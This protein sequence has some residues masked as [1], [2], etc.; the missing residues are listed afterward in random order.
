[1]AKR[2]ERTHLGQKAAR[3][4]DLTVRS[5]DRQTQLMFGKWVMRFLEKIGTG[6]QAAA[7]DTLE[8]AGCLFED[9]EWALYWA[10]SAID[11][12][13]CL[14]SRSRAFQEDSVD[15]LRAIGRLRPAVY[16]LMEDRLWGKPVWLLHFGFLE[17]SMEQAYQFWKFQYELALFEARLKQLKQFMRRR[18]TSSRT[19]TGLKAKVASLGEAVLHLYIKECTGGVYHKETSILLEAA[20]EAYNLEEKTSFAQD[21]VS[22]RYIRFRKKH[23][24]ELEETERD[25]AELWSERY[26]GSRVDLIPFLMARRKARFQ[27]LVR[28]CQ[29]ISGSAAEL[30]ALETALLQMNRLA[31]QGKKIKTAMKKLI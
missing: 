22:H 2:S 15:V 19:I 11:T 30:N 18:K 5:L 31:P 21:A 9:L 17:L 26:K 3:V 24:K 23:R 14:P 27:L 28:D 4:S 13:T 12:S 8:E 7:W 10:I 29:K 1:M 16:K 25:I 20:A 6:E